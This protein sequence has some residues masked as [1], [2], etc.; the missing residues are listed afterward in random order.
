MRYTTNPDI[1]SA[2]DVYRRLYSIWT[3]GIFQSCRNLSI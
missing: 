1:P 2:L 3:A